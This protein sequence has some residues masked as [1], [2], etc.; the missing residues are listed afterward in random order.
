ML[1]SEYVDQLPDE[2]YKACKLSPTTVTL[3]LDIPLLATEFTPGLSDTTLTDEK[4]VCVA[5]TY[6]AKP[7][8][9]TDPL[10]KLA[11]YYRVKTA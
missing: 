2:A 5:A 9:V 4:A 7:Q 6:L 11:Q 1:V 3:A 8:A 10:L